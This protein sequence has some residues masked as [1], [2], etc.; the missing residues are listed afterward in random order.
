MKIAFFISGLGMGGAEKVV[1]SIADLLVEKG[2]EVLIVY[3]TGKA[4]VL[5]VNSEVR[6]MGLELKSFEGLAFAYF[7]LRQILL[8]FKPDVLHSHMFH[9]NILARLLRLS[10]PIPRLISTAHSIKEGGRLRMLAY[11]L[12]DPMTDIST[13]V[14]QEAVDVFIEQKA[15]RPGR[16][17]AIH[18]GISTDDFFYDE[19]LER[20]E[21]KKLNLDYNLPV[22]LAVGRISE[23]KD[24]P[25]L[26][27]AFAHILSNDISGYLLIAGDGPLKNSME[28]LAATLCPPENVHFLG[29]HSNIPELML[30]CDVF[31]LSSAWEGFGLVVA[32]AMAS[33]RVVVATD[34]GGVREVLGNTGFLVPPRDSS[35]LSSAIMTA[36]ELPIKERRRLGRLARERIKSLYSIDSALVKWLSLYQG[37]FP[38]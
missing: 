37:K 28:A 30:A 20:S 25:N 21:R 8:D 9:A 29:I 12:T 15:A 14:S 4:V 6:V 22:L 19:E 27:H 32:E 34:C 16:M 11:R 5:P 18:N 36:L 35:A 1:T 24:Y 7:K 31:V 2:N 38:S 17:I 33:E 10:I 23:P 13:N 26:L 3:L